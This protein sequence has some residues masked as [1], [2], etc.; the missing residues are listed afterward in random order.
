MNNLAIAGKK[1]LVKVSTASGGTYTTVGQLNNASIN[2][3][4]NNFDVTA[5]GSS[6]ITRLQGLKNASYS[7]SGFFMTTDTN[8]QTAVRT[9][10]VNDSA[11]YA[12]FLVDGTTGNGFQQ[13][14]K[15]SA[16]DVSASVDGAVELSISFEGTDAITVYTT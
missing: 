6:W 16:Y 12:Q 7:L 15:V 4:G 11:L 5:F 2:I 13:E 10:L 9:A 8:G 1:L 14:V 3:A